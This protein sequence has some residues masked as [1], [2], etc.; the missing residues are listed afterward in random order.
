ME[1]AQLYS[2]LQQVEISSFDLRYEH[3]RLKSSAA[4]KV[5]LSSILDHGI[6]DPLQGVCTE[7]GRRVLLDGFKRYRCAK[8]L[9]IGVVP[10]HCLAED[11]ACGI[12]ELLRISNAKSLSIL[13]Q[14]RL[15]DELHNIHKMSV[16][17]IAVLLE[18][19]TAW[20]SLRT[21]I[22]RQMSECVAES[23]F[24][25]A[26]PV[27]SFMYTLRQFMRINSVSKQDIDQFVKAVA[28]KGLSI[29][30]IE[31][32]ANGYFKGSEAIREQIRNGNIAWGLSRLKESAVTADCTQ[33]EQRML[34]DLEIILK[35]LQR[36]IYKSKDQRYKSASYNAQVNLLAGGILRQMNL[37]F[38]SIKELYD[39][40]G[41][42]SSDLPVAP[43]RDE[44]TQDSP[45]SG[46]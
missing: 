13:E 32:L 6:R 2:G 11:E 40:S 21:G 4:E 24:S 20:V 27:Y 29:R 37:F 18:R 10:F 42:K 7:D 43:G 28:G 35:Y 8:K 31:T 45:K 19:S 26:F 23:I 16:S 33:V 3:C 41:Q 9:S 30:D 44:C 25:G 38:K 1:K 46:C 39:K 22:T 17:E 36:V 15:I 5:L 12:V 34:K 14:A